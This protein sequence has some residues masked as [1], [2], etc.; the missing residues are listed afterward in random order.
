[1]KDTYNISYCAL[2]RL[3]LVLMAVPK[4]LYIV[5]Y[6]V[7]L[8]SGVYYLCSGESKDFPEGIILSNYWWGNMTG[9]C[10]NLYISGY[11]TIKWNFINIRGHCKT[12]QVNL[13]YMPG[14][15]E[16]WLMSS[17]AYSR[18]ERGVKITIAIDNR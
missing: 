11:R 13:Y 1:M 16:T 15:G 5:Y 12:V 7:C 3:N 2:E 4:M 14:L 6:L 8:Y 10:Y 17:Q 9:I 18:M